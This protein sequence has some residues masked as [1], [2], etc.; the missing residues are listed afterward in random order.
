ML[1]KIHLFTSIF[2]QFPRFG[3]VKKDLKALIDTD[4]YTGKYIPPNQRS[5]EHIRPSSR[6]GEDH[7]T[8]YLVVRNKI[9]NKRE[10][11]PFI[12]WLL[13]GPEICK[14]LKKSQRDFGGNLQS[15]IDK[16]RYLQIYDRDDETFY[17]Y[18]QGIIPTLNKESKGLFIFKG[19]N[20]FLSIPNTK[21]HILDITSS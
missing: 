4:A 17:S 14:K 16:Y 3:G 11:M 5:I 20:K 19:K 8:N 1:P 9:N 18:G 21:E 7:W 12:K 6:K 15:Y 10:N 2:T 13:N